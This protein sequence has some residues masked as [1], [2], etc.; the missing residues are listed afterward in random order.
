MHLVK[1][2]GLYDGIIGKLEILVNHLPEC[3]VT[4]NSYVWDGKRIA[5][6]RLNRIENTA[7]ISLS[8]LYYCIICFPED[9]D[10]NIEILKN[11]IKLSIENRI[12][13]NTRLI[14]IATKTLESNIWI[15]NT[16]YNE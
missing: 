4:K 2:L 13:A 11:H 14:E 9:I 10:S 6:N 7:N 15:Q 12:F 8:D 5:K 1:I 3:T 16:I